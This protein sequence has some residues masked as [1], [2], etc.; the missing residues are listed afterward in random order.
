MSSIIAKEDLPAALQDAELVDVMVAAANA[1]ASRVAPCLTWDGAPGSDTPAPSAGTVAEAQLILIGA[2]KR[3]IESG[4]GALQT[5]TA[6][7]FGMTTDTRSRTGYALWPS[8]INAL[9]E[10]CSEGRDNSAAAF[11]VVPSGSASAHVPWCSLAFGAT[12]C[13]CGAD[14]TNYE[15]P[16]YEDGY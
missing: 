3:W 12:Y 7:P 8:E 15:Y 10:V 13:S 1:K 16:L 14:L 4:S 11:S 6:G 5:Q 9:Q 2:V